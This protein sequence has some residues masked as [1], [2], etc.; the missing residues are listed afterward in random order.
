MKYEELIENISPKLKAISKKVKVRYTYCDE[1]DF[2]Q[3]AL[4]HLWC[5]FKN[6][7]LG[8]KTDS[9]ILQ[10]CYY[11]L[12]NYIRKICKSVDMCSVS[13]DSPA[14]EE[15]CAIADSIISEAYVTEDNS[16]EIFFF[17]DNA[18][19]SFN[20]RE[21]DVF[22]YQLEGYTTREIGERIGVSHVAVVKTSTRIRE[23]CRVLK[24]EN[25]WF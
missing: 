22:Y 17:M 3:E 18:E 4:L 14:N 24:Y 13:L 5:Q 19:T 25:D 12:K 7:A 1:D 21:K 2:Y 11:F 9:Y 20:E 6:N 8:D 10:G 15:G 23:K 16:I